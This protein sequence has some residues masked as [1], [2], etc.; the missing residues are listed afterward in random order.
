MIRKAV[1]L[2]QPGRTG[3]EKVMHD[4]D[5]FAKIRGWAPGEL[6]DF[7]N[8]LMVLFPGEL[9]YRLK[10]VIDGLPNQG[11]NTQRV[12]ELV[13][14]QWREMQTSDCMQI[15][16]AGPAK[17]G[18][19]SLVRA[20]TRKQVSVCESVFSIVDTRRLDEFLGYREE[21][22]TEELQSA[23]VIILVLDARFGVSE[24]TVQ[25]LGQLKTLGKPL[26]VVLNKIDL[27]ERAGDAVREARSRLKGNVFPMS[28][29]QEE[30]IRSLLKAIIAVEPRALYAL[31]QNFPEFRNEIC[32]G[33]V[34]QSAFAS[35]V[36]AAIPMPISDLLPLSAI[37]AAMVLKISRAF[38]FKI[39]RERARELLPVLALGTAVREGTHWLRSRFEEHKEAIGVSVAGLWTYVLG[40]A[41]I[42]YFEKLA[43]YL[44]AEPLLPEPAESE[45][46]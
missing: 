24:S 17:T 26:L 46:A 11:D 29:F 43:G 13:R 25:M 38:G 32:G 14:N 30:K 44:Q 21:S 5:V 35:S 33:I 16:V 42:A 9:K 34:T 20:I 18:K 1:A 4:I 3:L 8:Q 31:T 7:L 27:V 40:Q 6:I 2:L 28:V 22:V 45:V 19:A 10:Q 36:V 12:I 23:N 15:A 41:A 39:N 37:Q